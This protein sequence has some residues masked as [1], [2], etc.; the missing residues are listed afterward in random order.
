MALQCHTLIVQNAFSER[1]SH[2]GFNF[3]L[4]LVVDLLHEF[5]LGVWKSILIHL[6]CIV[7]SLKGSVL[8]ELNHRW[9]DLFTVANSPMK[10]VAQGFARCLP[11]A[12]I[13]FGGSIRISL[14]WRGWQLEILRMC[15]RSVS[16][17]R[18]CQY[19]LTQHNWCVVFNPCFCRTVARSS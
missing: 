17:F 6:L 13:P 5:E 11:S 1:L 8:A 19:C 14:N 9:E 16:V 18:L 2:T 15:Y 10:L 3:F 4:M 12:E 7:D